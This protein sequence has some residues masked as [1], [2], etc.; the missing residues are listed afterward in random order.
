MSQPTLAEIIAQG[1]NI[2]VEFKSDRGPLDD[3]DLLDTVVCMANGQGG[4]LL[5]GVENDGTI[6]GLHPSHRTRPELLAAFVNSRTVPP[7]TVQVSFKEAGQPGTS[8]S[9]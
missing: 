2:T 5:I 4:L 6:T 3:G 8:S 9:G 7:L 1:E